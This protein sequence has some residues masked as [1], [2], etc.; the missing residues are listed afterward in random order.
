MPLERFQSSYPHNSQE[1]NVRGE[2][3]PTQEPIFTQEQKAV[4]QER[5][6]E[7]LDTIVEDEVKLVVFLDRSARPFAWML[8]EA[9]KKYAPGKSM[10]AVKFINLGGE[11][12]P[13]YGEYGYV[14]DI[15]EEY[16]DTQKDYQQA[17][18]DFWAKLNTKQY[19]VSL[20][21]DIQPILEGENVGTGWPPKGE[22]LL[23]DDYQG[24]GFTNE[25]ASAFFR[26]HFPEVR[27]LY[28]TILRQEDRKIF[29]KDGWEGVHLPWNT[30]KAY[31]LLGE[32]ENPADILATSERDPK[33]RRKGLAL[34]HEIASWFAVAPDTG[35]EP[36]SLPEVAAVRATLTQE[37]GRLLLPT[38]ETLPS[39]LHEAGAEIRAI[40]G[41]WNPVELYTA[42]PTR[43]EQQK[44]LFLEK[45][46]AGED[47]QPEFI[48]PA[49][50]AFPVAE[51]RAKLDALVKRMQSLAVDRED[52]VARLARVIVRAK[53]QDD[54]ATCDLA[55]GIQ[56]KDE[57]L[58]G[59]AIRA[60]YQPID[61]DLVARARVD[62]ER[63]MRPEA[64]T[65]AGK[66]LLTPEEQ[67]WLRRKKFTA[68]EIKAA[69]EWA[70]A[71]FQRPETVPPGGEY[72]FA[73][74]VDEHA[75]SIDVRDKSAE[76][77]RIV[78]PS[79][80]TVDGRYLLNLL[81]HE[82]GA[83][84]RQS[85]NGM[86]LFHVG[87]GAF[88]IDDETAYEGLAM[89]NEH[90]Y[91]T[92]FF[93][94]PEDDALS[95]YVLAANAAEQGHSFSEIFREQLELRLR[96]LLKIDP[97]VQVPHSSWIDAKVYTEAQDAAWFTTYRV[98]RGHVD[99][100][101]PKGFAMTK[102][103]AYFRGIVLDDQLVESGLG[104]LNEAAIFKQGG[105]KAL[106]EFVLEPEDLP[107]QNVD[108]AKLYWTE[109]LQPQYRQELA[110]SQR[111]EA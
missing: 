97:S 21:R 111:V 90:A 35:H 24:T 42:D 106:A 67:D 27:A 88:K 50:E 5:T 1:G 108:L 62:A 79:A 43:R 45:F 63:R 69:F 18:Q 13:L 84:A 6:K 96:W 109:V 64:E 40:S 75:S 2:G 22:I 51:N 23:V 48:Y 26:H 9:W 36:T 39:F 98:M 58:I 34:K 3:A 54:L 56:R 86:A 101:N 81:V 31:T 15:W 59:R 110:A 11:K 107:F 104:H 85:L 46:A 72:G 89:R 52:R 60:K 25:L 71:K 103:L 91:Y 12:V 100:S 30:D 61:P 95:Q 44:K 38:A 77:P 66:A 70:L 80:K 57:A 17:V 83:H 4:L 99:T 102:D 68:S 87:G 7:L 47:Y 37:N 33:K 78:I 8:R 73:V 14:G 53:L 41:R 105:L 65:P 49:A 19:V 16:Y 29:W 20:R 93:G 10:P 76:G 74:V 82:I 92:E 32:S 94:K 55:E 28:H